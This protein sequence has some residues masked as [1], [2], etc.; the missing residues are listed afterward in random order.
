M[1]NP[2]HSPLPWRLGTECHVEVCDNNGNHL[3][4]LDEQDAALVVSAVNSR[5]ELPAAAKDV[6]FAYENTPTT[7]YP[8]AYVGVFYKLQAAIAKAEG[9]SP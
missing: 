7:D 9:R 8:T 4:I 5:D 6:I 3:A 2:T 1:M